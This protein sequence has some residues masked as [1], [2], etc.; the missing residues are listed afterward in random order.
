MAFEFEL[1]CC[2]VFVGYTITVF[3]SFCK[4]EDEEVQVEEVDIDEIEEVEEEVEVDEEEVEEEEEKEKEKDIYMDMNEVEDLLK[5]FK[6]KDGTIVKK[7]DLIELAYS[8]YGFHPRQQSIMEKY[9]VF[10]VDDSYRTPRLILWSY[11]DKKDLTV[12]QVAE[13]MPYDNNKMATG[14]EVLGRN[15]KF[16]DYSGETRNGVITESLDGGNFAVSSGFGSILVT[17]EM[18]ISFD[19]KPQEVKKKLF[20]FF[21][22]GGNIQNDIAVIYIDEYPY[23]LKK[24]GD[25]T[26]FNMSNSKEGVDLVI[27]SHIGQHSGT[28]YYN[29]IRSW[30]K[31]GESPDGK[32]YIDKLKDG[33]TIPDAD[34]KS[35][36]RFLNKISNRVDKIWDMIGAKSGG[37]IRTD[38]E[39]LGSYAEK[40][41]IEVEKLGLKKNSLTS[42]DF[43]FFTNRNDH[44]LNE[45]LVWN[46]FYYTK[47]AKKEKL[48][49][50]DLFKEYPLSY[51]DP[52]IIKVV[53]DDEKYIPHSKIDSITVIIDGKEVRIQGKDVLN[54][55]NR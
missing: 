46:N 13:L 3:L 9:E 47:F 11:G 54:G 33:G 42:K 12:S 4:D 52:S 34:K 15:I 7:G 18:V 14:G 2:T 32:R 39:M 41:L 37:Q 43:A 10:G 19:E 16:K 29:D 31:G 53:T 20:G 30:L 55:A 28:P 40:A 35:D 21:E 48:N 51:C 23:Y 6:Y 22:E 27:P 5:Q 50:L 25:S 44:L 17:P 36:G 49:Y 8:K 24:L 1:L 45:F 38:K 26:H